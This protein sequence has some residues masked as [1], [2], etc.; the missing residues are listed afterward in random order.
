MPQKLRSVGFVGRTERGEVLCASSA[1]WQVM[2]G[3][4]EW[5]DTLFCLAI[6]P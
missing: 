3:S 1:V 4:G 6:W 5:C 2:Q